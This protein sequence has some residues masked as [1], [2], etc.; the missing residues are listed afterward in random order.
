MAITNDFDLSVK[1][2]DK[3]EQKT[4]ARDR[5]AELLAKATD[6]PANQR[7]RNAVAELQN[8]GTTTYRGKTYTLPEGTQ[9]AATT[10]VQTT[11]P[12]TGSGL[13]LPTAEEYTTRQN[14]R[15][16]N[17]ATSDHGEKVNRRLYGVDTDTS[18]GRA[19]NEPITLKDVGKRVG[20]VVG[21]TA[22]NFISGVGNPLYVM[23]RIMEIPDDILYAV[24]KN[25]RFNLDREPGLRDSAA[26]RASDTFAEAAQEASDR[27]GGLGKQII[28][29]GQAAGNMMSSAALYGGLFNTL[30]NAGTVAGLSNIAESSPLLTSPYS[31]AGAKAALE[32]LGSPGNFGIS[33]GS[34]VSSYSEALQNGARIGQAMTNGL[35]K[36]LAEYFSNKLF[37]GTPF[38]NN[39]GEKGYVTKLTEYLANKLGKSKV[40]EEFNL[41]TG[42]KVFNWL[43]D[44]M[45]E[46]MEEV[47][48]GIADPLIDK[49]TYNWD[50][51][52][53][54]VDQLADEF[55]GGVLLSLIMS[56]GEALIDGTSGRMTEAK[57]A[58]QLT[59]MGIDAETAKAYAGAVAEAAEKLNAAGAAAEEGAE[60][61][62]AVEAGMQATEEPPANVPPQPE[63]PAPAAQNVPGNAETQAPETVQEAPAETPTEASAVDIPAEVQSIPQDVDAAQ[64]PMREAAKKGGLGRFG[65]SFMS[66]HYRDSI[67][68]AEWYGEFAAYYFNGREDGDIDSVRA[69]YDN[70]TSNEKQ[71]AWNAGQMDVEDEA[72]YGVPSWNAVPEGNGA[73]SPN[74]SGL[75]LPTVET[76]AETTAE[77]GPNLRLPT[78]EPLTP[79]AE[80]G[81]METEYSTPEGTS[82][83][84]DLMRYNRLERNGFEYTLTRTSAGWIGRLRDLRSDTNVGGVPVTNARAL[85]Y[86][87]QPMGSRE[88]AVNT[89]VQVAERNRLLGEASPSFDESPV[90]D[91]AK[92][93]GV[94]YEEEAALID[95]KSSYSYLINGKIRE[96]NETEGADP[97]EYFDNR[98]ERFMKEM[99]GALEKLPIHKGRVYRNLTFDDFGGEEEYRKFLEKHTTNSIVYYPAYTSSSTKEDGYPVEGEY[100]VRLVIESETGR[101]VD[102]FGNNFENEVIHQRDSVFFISDAKEE[103][104]IPTIYMQEVPDERKNQKPETDTDRGNIP[105]VQSVPASDSEKVRLPGVPGQDS[106]RNPVKSG[107]SQEAVSGGSRNSV[108]GE[109]LK[110]P[111]AEDAAKQ[112]TAP[113]VPEGTTDKDI[114]AQ[115]GISNRLW[116]YT[117]GSKNPVHGV[118]MS[119]KTAYLGNG[120][121]LVEVPDS[122]ES[123]AL[124]DRKYGG[125]GAQSRDLTDLIGKAKQVVETG[126]AV[127][128]Q[129]MTLDGDFYGGQ[130][131]KNRITYVFTTPN[132]DRK[133]VG[134]E[135][136]GLITAGFDGKLYYNGD[137]NLLVAANDDGTVHGVALFKN[138]TLPN[139]WEDKARPARLKN[140]T[141]ETA[142][143]A[144]TVEST[145]AEEPK[146][147]TLPT[148]EK[149]PEAPKKLTAPTVEGELKAHEKLA[150]A[151]V[152]ELE[153]GN[154]ITS[155]RLQELADKAYGGTRGSGAYD[156]K[157]AYDVLEL[158]V[159]KYLM[160]ADFVQNA[161]GDAAAAV[162]T[163]EALQQF[164]GLLPTQTVR[165]EEQQAFQQFSTPPNIAYLAAWAANISGADTVLEPSAGI[166]GL[167]LWPKA[168]GATVYGNELSPRRAE[169]LR[170]LGLDEVFTENAEQINNV[171]PD[172]VKP[173]VVLMNPPFSATAGR[174]SVNNTANA[175]RH[176]EQAL[177]RLEDGGRL[178]AI[179]GRGMANDSKTFS[180]W[181]DDLRKEYDIKANLSING[182]NYKKYGTTFD[183]QLV[184]IDKTGPQTGE[185]ITGSYDDLTEIPQVLEG[186]RNDRTQLEAN[187]TNAGER[188]VRA[189]A[190][191]ER[192]GPVS[193]RPAGNDQRLAGDS[194]GNVGSAASESSGNGGRVQPGR[195]GENGR[196][197]GNDS[198]GQ[199]LGDQRGETSGS[200]H[201]ESE[202]KRGAGPE[203]ELSVPR[204]TE[205]PAKPEK[206]TAA[207]TQ[208]AGN[209][210]GVYAEYVPPK[211]PVK[212]TKK[213]PAQIVESA[214]M[215]AVDAPQATYTP[216]I[217]KELITSGAL[218]D[219]QLTNIVYAG[220]AHSQ[221][222]PNQNIRRGYFIG[223]GTGVGKGRQIAGIIL[224]NFRQGRTKAV[225]ISQRQN[226]LSDAK[227]DWKAMGMDEKDILATAKIKADK[228]IEAPRG[229]LFTTYD[230]LANKSKP[231]KSRLDQIVNWLGPDFDGVIALDEAHTM[232]NLLG[233][234]GK[235]GN[236]K[237]AERALAGA[238]LQKRLPNARIVYASATMATDV[239]EMA[240]AE[241]LGLWGPGTQ[242][243]NVRDFVEKISSGG[244]AAMELVARD[245]KA[246]GLYQ[247]RSISYNGVQY[248]T[249]QHDL[250]PM[251]KE[252]YDTMSRAWQVTLKH[253]NEA[254]E[255]TG[256]NLNGYAK[257]AAKS[258]YYGAMQ[259][260]YNQILTSMAMP[261]VI[262]DIKKELAAGRSCVLQIVNTNEAETNRQLAKIQE[263]GGD[264]EDLDIT[265]R[266]NLVGF[267]RN[268]FPV[269]V[270]EEYEDE[271][272]NKRSRPVTDSK[273]NPVLDKKAVALR[274]R[275]IAEI[276]A[277][278]VPEG[279][280]EML[281]DAFGVDQV[282]EV[283]GR[284]RRVVPGKDEYGNT[285]RVEEKRGSG[286]GEADAQAFQDGK[287]HILVFSDAG[288]T[289][290]SYHA[291]LTAKNQ[292]QRVHYLIQAGWSAPKAVQG[293]GRTN[294]SNQA[295][296]PI[297]KLVTTDVK[298]QKRFISTIARR[299][300]QLGALTKGQRQTGSGVFSARDNLESDLATDTL[301]NFYQALV[302]D[303]LEGLDP[304][305][306]LEKLGLMEKFTD[307]ETGRIKVP[308]GDGR[309]MSLFL[310][311]ILALEYDE[312][313]AVFDAFNRMLDDAYET[314]LANGTL[315]MGMETV[316][317]DKIDIVDDMTVREDPETGVA[318][319]YVQAK[320]SEK[321]RI[322]KT[323]DDLKALRGDFIGIYRKKNGEA[324]GVFR[325]KDKTETNGNVV[326][327]YILQSPLERKFSRYVEATLKKECERL[328]EKEWNKAWKAEVEKTPEYTE[329]IKHMLTGSLLP[330]WNKLPQSG[331]VRVQRLIADDGRQYLG[332]IIDPSQI[333]SVLKSLG[334]TKG[335]TKQ[336]YTADDVIKRVLK[337][338]DKATLENN[339]IALTRRRVGGEMRIEVTGDN[340]WYL[341]RTNPD[342]I[343]E[344][345]N[346]RPR[347][348]LPTGDRQKPALEKLLKENPVLE[349][350]QQRGETEDSRDVDNFNGN[351]AP[352]HPEDWKT[353]RVGDKD[354]TPMSL[355]DIVDMI[356]HEYG[357]PVTTGNIR[358]PEARA[359]YRRQA[360]SIRTKITGSIRDISHELG[361]HLDNLYDIKHNISAAARR[362]IIDALPDGFKD[363]YEK[364][365]LPGEGVAE[366]VRRY[367]LNSETAKMDYPKF[368]EEFFSMLDAKATATLDK[369]ADEMNAYY[370]LSEETGN[371]PVHNREDRG[372]DYRGLAEKLKDMHSRFRSAF[373]ETMEPIR[374]AD[375]ES[376][377][378]T[379]MFAIN[380]AYAGNRAYAAI[381][382]DLYDLRGNK[383]GEG[384]QKALEGIHLNRKQEYKDFGWYLICRHGPERL[385]EG[386]QVTSNDAWDNTAYM[387]SVVEMMEAKYPAFAEA[388]ERLEEFQRKV[389]EA[390]GVETGLYS[391]ETIDK[392]YERWEHYVPFNRWFG[393]R[394]SKGQKKGFANQTG[395]YKKAVGSGRDIINPVD[396]IMENTVRLITASVYNDVMQKLTKEVAGAEGLAYLMEKVPAPLARK[397]WDGKGLKNDTLEAFEEVFS[398]AGTTAGQDTMDM[399]QRILDMAIDDVLVQY[400]RG[401]AHGDIVTVMKDGTPE[402]WKI[403]DP[404][405]LRSLTNMG[406]GRASPI[407]QTLG[408]I[409]RFIT[410]N[411]TGMNVVWSIASNMPRDLGTMFTF[412]KTKN[413]A[414][415]LSGMAEGYVNSLRGD[416]A[417]ELYKEFIAMGGGS[418]S[419]QTADKDMARK[420][421]KALQKKVTDWLDPLEAVEF[422]SDMIERGPRYSYYK[423]CRTRYGMTPEE[424]FYAAMEITT[425]FKRAGYLGREINMVIPF[426]NASVQGVDRAARWIAAE[427]VPKES[428]KKARTGRIAAYLGASL[429]IAALISALN[430]GSK[431]KR[432]NYEKLSAYTKNNYFVIPMKNGKYLAIPKP[433]ELAIPIS[434][435][436]RV[437]E[438]YVINNGHAFDEFY[439][440]ATDNLLPGV[441]SGVA[442]GDL[443]S[444]IGDLGV[445]G[446]VH[447]LVSNQDFLGRPIVSSGLQDLEPK[448]QYNQKTSELAYMIGQQLNLSP[449]KI[450]FLGNEILGGF[451]NWQKAVAPV[452]G[453]SDLSLGVKS[454]WVKDPLYSTDITNR[455]YEA[456]D[457]A[458]R[459]K[460]SHP[461]DVEAA[462]DYRTV[463]DMASFYGKYYKLAKGEEE[464]EENREIRGAMLDMILGVEKNAYESEPARKFMLEV[465][466][467]QGSAELMPTVMDVTV[468]S[469]EGQVYSLTSK[470]YFELQT[471][472]NSLYYNYIREA[473]NRQPKM[474]MEEKTATV[475]AAKSIAGIV[476][477][478]EAIEAHGGTSK[479]YDKIVDLYDQDIDEGELMNFLAAKTVANADGKVTNSELMGAVSGLRLPTIG[480]QAALV[481]YA[482]ESLGLKLRA[483]SSYDVDAGDYHKVL[484]ALGG[485]NVTQSNVEDAID[486]VY[487]KTTAKNRKEKAAMW[488]AF[489]KGWKA[490]NNPY[491]TQVSSAVQ[492]KLRL[493]TE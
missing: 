477:R 444:A 297:Y 99:D 103:D 422:F 242:F 459:R 105:A 388:A 51:D 253:M 275:M 43:F 374:Q 411:I 336:T 433:R 283:T 361:H 256:A 316:R 303:Q 377:G 463:N 438:A 460:N 474:S 292:E 355:P 340:L 263:T 190:G 489:N 276:E 154:T 161:N 137:S 78:A 241:R 485:N 448:D 181:W 19:T 177:D 279:P 198:N 73:E 258:A 281:F 392:W 455:L 76:T 239:N 441:V 319:N 490:A 353:E 132:G 397:T 339:R 60:E 204:V 389:L 464:T 404:D 118:D 412:S 110:L 24:T 30:G 120:Q 155:K 194:S 138:M 271:N 171:L 169:I 493:P 344:T 420:A 436:E 191:S 335:R 403:N 91:A 104:G 238:E 128:R 159:N 153:E 219:V 308:D 147:P 467:D 300:D 324:V 23:A 88:E 79:A 145:P 424:A 187:A 141:P 117:R 150:E 429:A 77:T 468:K 229:I 70:M 25:E 40:L 410:G 450:D 289:G 131:G 235:R 234:K 350:N 394:E 294:R 101:D 178:V 65:V 59:E 405:L 66:G 369:L 317:A 398:Q 452:S 14:R 158:A 449:Q 371:W 373:V 107:G 124:Q 290:K 62:P 228:S 466:E 74:G 164:M 479:D 399:I 63:V 259:R 130:T 102:G 264:L 415:I 201:P 10:P 243:S 426:F 342:I 329:T 94:T 311:R 254:L 97:A 457:K 390:Y 338:G 193:A 32:I 425:N 266:E 34:G 476:A 247:A 182:E 251:Q 421:R 195:A 439:E 400:S 488:Q 366:F 370:S 375:E 265:P 469:D 345:I 151:L 337:D 211:T 282:A 5:L 379:H 9:P 111:A 170:S 4:G 163:E 358:S 17:T 197:P 129:P 284:K 445:V 427:D 417:V 90:S 236:S 409:N 418:T 356:R 58:K 180:R 41:T 309:D 123:V 173:S 333:D 113:T 167:A 20:N 380:S 453:E 462:V 21:G 152:A 210:D 206:K 48:T 334:V 1:K 115:N 396:N 322:V 112:P 383:L 185:T 189:H 482:N 268:S 478:G 119:T 285:V 28:Q 11:T 214:A 314:A 54:T 378:N 416:K 165:T 157:T 305:S 367:L 160:G 359:Q 95:Y 89:L 408:R 230:T 29:T 352:R 232:G 363:K 443:N 172:Y 67:S 454:K 331:N 16:G 134:R 250:T 33:L 126:E 61:A 295:S 328:P 85:Q 209:D 37:S 100:R 216:N 175:K 357:I 304:L 487:G 179:L 293:F 12:S 52:L 31:R 384:L 233:K 240:F 139:G 231:G 483:V 27:V 385:A 434:L 348:F 140:I 368:S 108:R 86:M 46:G 2:E 183:V 291:D 395:P 435:F 393:D 56:G 45:G 246:M 381:T 332:R 407:I 387:E 346:Y 257:S 36:G 286:S 109:G 38:E 184:V 270:Y 202:P 208:K 481:G 315:D 461:D 310:N 442:Q 39:P 431:K 491:D 223:D 245:M 6:T 307:K 456:R 277:M 321:A 55:L 471:R 203:S 188:G 406:P 125:I 136:I 440:Y 81:K 7:S 362:E 252:I 93:Y 114:A 196:R 492:S 486:A 343:S 218:S 205:K 143:K 149:T 364:A 92:Q 298:G 301:Y 288:G 44:K 446:S 423:I 472:Y 166:G 47:V 186:I 326:K 96:F 401:K 82:L 3:K 365:E 473:M 347:Y 327:Q 372:K 84:G 354:K 199:R 451:W 244:M 133:T 306:V 57:I 376:G 200:L 192:N 330:I 237:P 458:K 391:Q 80:S 42:G 430:M 15:F 69:P 447:Y 122:A 480:E 18:A 8:T 320:L 221:M 261:S 144:P 217:P 176:I 432:E 72:T 64:V 272:G 360:Q 260:F 296:A 278:S 437:M 402:F 269:Q 174:L 386:M 323:V 106:E 146:K 470:E 262:E 35:Y 226:L 75:R 249:I 267:F 312:Q 248:D 419:A 168:W 465:I 53:V 274:D 318:T 225:W 87:T 382:G 255:M 121:A 351:N 127:T 341:L 162:R 156:I 224:D 280:M 83:A 325:T 71:T 215:A 50:A 213:H 68:P 428:R 212:G 207:A 287:K 116:S 302:R 313:N 413:I 273:G 49:L 142:L 220:Q 299:L 13:K 414:E 227:R 475:K 148:A 135:Q 22:A 484:E 349:I 98:D 26:L 222:I